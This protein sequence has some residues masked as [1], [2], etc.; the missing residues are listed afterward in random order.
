HTLSDDVRATTIE[1]KNTNHIADC[2]T[3][4]VAKSSEDWSMMKAK[5][6]TLQSASA[7]LGNYDTAFMPNVQSLDYGS[8]GFPPIDLLQDPVFH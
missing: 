3:E 1:S 5:G 4:D 8:Y 7:L 6:K 2:I